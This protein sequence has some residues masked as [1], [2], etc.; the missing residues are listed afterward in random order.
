[1][2]VCVCLQIEQIERSFLTLSHQASQLPIIFGRSC[3]LHPVSA[4]N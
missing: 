4:K 2:C 1:M 3:R